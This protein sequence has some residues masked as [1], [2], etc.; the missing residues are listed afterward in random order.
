MRDLADYFI[1][2]YVYFMFCQRFC[3]KSIKLCCILHLNYICYLKTIE[4]LYEGTAD[5]S[6]R[7]YSEACLKKDLRKYTVAS[8]V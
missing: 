5:A 1:C 3:L 7:A 4:D 2:D 8:S 6:T